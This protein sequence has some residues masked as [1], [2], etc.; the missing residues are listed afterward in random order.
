MWLSTARAQRSGRGG[1]GRAAHDEV[2]LLGGPG[3]HASV[4]GAPGRRPARRRRP[5]GAT[6][7][8]ALDPGS[9]ALVVEVAG[10]RHTMFP[11]R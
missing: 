8:A 6:G 4:A 5:P 9:Q 7:E 3:E 11:G 2:R 1:R 10:R